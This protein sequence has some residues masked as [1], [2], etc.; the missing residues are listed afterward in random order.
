MTTAGLDHTDNIAHNI[1]LLQR[2][3]LK[4]EFHLDHTDYNKVENIGTGMY[5]GIMINYTASVIVI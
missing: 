4:V 2:Q 5:L 3:S 1:Q